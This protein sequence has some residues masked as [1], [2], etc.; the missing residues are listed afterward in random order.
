MSCLSLI[1]THVNMKN[2]LINL[3]KSIKI[4]TLEMEYNDWRNK[5]KEFK[6]NMYYYLDLP[7]GDKYCKVRR[8]EFFS[9]V[10]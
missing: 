5:S 2:R 7:F 1:F 9:T 6:Q 3:F 8:L 10:Y 4:N